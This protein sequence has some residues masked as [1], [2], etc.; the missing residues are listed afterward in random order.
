MRITKEK[1]R[2]RKER[3]PDQKRNAIIGR[4]KEPRERE[5]FSENG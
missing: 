1:E 4:G 5:N 2:K 3:K